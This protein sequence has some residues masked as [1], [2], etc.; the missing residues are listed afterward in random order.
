MTY[1]VLARKWRPRRFAEMVGQAHVVRAL[2]NALSTGRLHHAY[3]FTGTRGVGKTTVARILAK[4]L[5]CE[6]GVTAEPC[7]T[8]DACVELDEGRFIDLIEV[9]AASR[10]RVDETRELMDNVQYAPTR[11]RFKVYLIDEV[12][13]FSKHSFNALLKTLEE[14]PPHV[15]FLLATTDPQKLPITV[16]SRCLQFHLRQL[17]DA[18]IAGHLEHLASAEGLQTEAGGLRA[19]ARAAR[20]SMRD[21]LSL[22]DQAIAYGAGEVNERD[23]LD[24]L[25]AV[26]PDGVWALLEALADGSGPALLDNLETL[27]ASAPDFDALMGD[28]LRAL[29]VI[30]VAQTVPE[31]PLPEEV[32]APRVAALVDRVAAEDIQ[33]WYQ[34][35]IMGRR[36][37]PW[38]VSARSGLEMTLMRMLAFRPASPAASSAPAS[39]GGTRAGGPA[40]QASASALQSRSSPTPSPTPPVHG[41]RAGS[42]V[43]ARDDS[44]GMDATGEGPANRPGNVPA[45]GPAINAGPKAHDTGSDAASGNDS[46]EALDAER[47][48]AAAPGSSVLPAPERMVDSAVVQSA[49]SPPGFAH[50]GSGRRDPASAEAANGPSRTSE[51]PTSDA[52]ADQAASAGA[53]ASALPIMGAASMDWA[54]IVERLA[55]SGLA[56]ELAYNCE[57]VARD[58]Q[59]LRLRMSPAHAHLR[60]GR[61]QAILTEALRSA[62]PDLARVDFDVAERDGES[63]AE[64]RDRMM[65]ERRVEAAEDMRS[66][67]LVASLGDYFGARVDPDGVQP[68]PDEPGSPDRPA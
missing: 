37:M 33:L 1:Q 4:G 64:R 41:A 29:Q 60:A 36:D 21:A 27:A 61:A 34:I 65:N 56:R 59:T 13:M 54:G 10:A 45:T 43:A 5:N 19:L 47:Q 44:S 35:G 62:L 28:L 42:G 23:V 57:C 58:E 38:A 18:Q 2:D 46:L 15:K 66:D 7:G 20:G 3:L 50:S 22:L 25:G 6:Q 26:D 14:P 30:A 24:M 11:G 31:A 8:C 48:S 49:A 52:A 67:P 40:A 51:S 9:D 39:D 16:L 63:P 12:H 53:A 55:L 32:P 68:T 17:P